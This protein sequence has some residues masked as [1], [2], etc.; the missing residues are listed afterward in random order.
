MPEYTATVLR[1][2]ADEF[3]SRGVTLNAGYQWGA[4]SIGA[5]Y[6]YADVTQGANAALPNSG[7]FMPVGHMATA[8]I[9]HEFV[10]YN[11]KVGASLSW[12]G[13]VSHA[14]ATGNGFLDQSSYTVVNAYA[15]WHPPINE[16]ITLR[17][18]VENLFDETYFER[19]SYATSTARGGIDPVFA[20]GR[21][22]TFKTTFTF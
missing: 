10:D 4:T 20:P 18:G 9:D 12:A 5:T 19:A 13:K 11:L 7:P 1:N 3:R 21:T 22:F 17:V 8:F 14:Y 2:Y 16:N 15:E 6:T